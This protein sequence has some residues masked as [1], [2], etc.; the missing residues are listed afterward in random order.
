MARGSRDLTSSEY[1]N[2]LAGKSKHSRSAREEIQMRRAEKRNA[3]DSDGVGYHFGLSDG[4]VKVES[5]EHL[6]HELNKR[7]LMLETDVRTNLRGPRPHEFKGRN[8]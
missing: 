2:Y 3:H 1:D 6:K 7:G 4:V 8:K 5:K